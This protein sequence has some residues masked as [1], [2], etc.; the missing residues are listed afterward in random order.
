[1][2][3]A[4]F[5]GLFNHVWERSSI[6]TNI[7]L[8]WTNLNSLRSNLWFDPAHFCQICNTHAPVSGSP[9]PVN[10][11]VGLGK[12]GH[13]SSITVKSKPAVSPLRCAPPQL[14]TDPAAC[15]HTCPVPLFH[16]STVPLCR[17]VSFFR[18]TN[19]SLNSNRGEGLMLLFGAAYCV[20]TRG[21]VC[22]L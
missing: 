12:C 19:E 15:V 17:F 8:L 2:I 22:S 1:M 18:W 10:V 6:S 21:H 20:Q 4:A 5:N 11:A 7:Q 13:L 3:S 16:C 9:K 14:D